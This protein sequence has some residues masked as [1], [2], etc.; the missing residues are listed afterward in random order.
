MQ[1]ISTTSQPPCCAVCWP[2]TRSECSDRAVT[3]IGLSNHP[4]HLVWMGGIQTWGLIQYKEAIYQYRKS[5]CGDKT[6]V[7]SSYLHNGISYTGKMTSLYWIRAQPSSMVMWW[8]GNE[9]GGVSWWFPSQR[10]G[11]VQWVSIPWRHHEILI[12]THCLLTQI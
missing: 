8:H 11:M 6:V 2:I 1:V 12:V 7:R 4:D 10:A 3:A 5:H 9:W